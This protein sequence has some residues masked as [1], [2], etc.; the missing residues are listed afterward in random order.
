MLHGYMSHLYSSR[1][2]TWD[3][4]IS[5]HLEA[6]SILQLQ[7]CHIELLDAIFEGTIHLQVTIDLEMH[8]DLN[9]TLVNWSD[10]VHVHRTS[11]QM[12][13]YLKTQQLTHII[14]LYIHWGSIQ[15]VRKDTWKTVQF[16]KTTRIESGSAI[17][18][19]LQNQKQSMPHM[20]CASFKAVRF[21][22]MYQYSTFSDT[23]R[24]S[25]RSAKHCELFCT[26]GQLE[27]SLAN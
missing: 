25:S 26:R 5:Q 2:F 10:W 20:K 23:D 21:I 9:V 27:V 4:A 24:S 16:F 7:M 18:Q 14:H 6:S 1:I 12:Y 17:R 13:K 8:T 15:L 3:S 19:G 22:W 11:V